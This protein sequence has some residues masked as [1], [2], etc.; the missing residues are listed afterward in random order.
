LK[1]KWATVTAHTGGERKNCPQ[2][3]LP[4]LAAALLLLLL[5]LL[6]LVALL[7]PVLLLLLLLLLFFGLPP[8]LRETCRLE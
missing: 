7:S 4:G 8:L 5:L 6:L 3:T 1:Q 2:G